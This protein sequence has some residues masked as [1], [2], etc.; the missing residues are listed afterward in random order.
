MPAHVV[1]SHHR[2][3]VW[4]AIAAVL[5]LAVPPLHGGEPEDT[6]PGP[7][8]PDRATSAAAGAAADHGD[9]AKKLQN[10][11][12]DLI[13]FPFQNITSLGVGPDD[14]TGNV[15]NLQPVV[16]LHIAS[17]WNLLMRPILPVAYTSVPDSE[18]GLGDLNVE[19]FLSPR[20]A[21]RVEWGAGVVVGVPTATGTLLG[22][23]Q[24]TA[25]PSF[26]L[27]AVQGHWTLSVIV[28]QQWSYAGD[29]ARAA[30]SLF[31]LQPSLSYLLGGGWFLTSGPLIS[32]D[33]TKESGQKWTVPAGMGVGRVVSI[34]GQKVNLQVEAYGNPIRPD[35]G[36]RSMVLVTATL[37]F[38][39]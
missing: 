6:A 16:P 5:L 1:T 35:D 39:R 27:F 7:V 13:T 30:V 26:A 17:K 38:P 12:A 34:G 2:E 37:L 29:D 14:G 24:W 33:W 3:P 21:G 4:L 10:P 22:T 28:N 9:L 8:A 23:G 18:F 19:P 25:G 36:P 31:Q 11:F 20:K 15:L 32:A